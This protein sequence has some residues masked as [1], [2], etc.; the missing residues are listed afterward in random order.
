MNLRLERV[1]SGGVS[2]GGLSVK[3]FASRRGSGREGNIDTDAEMHAL[4][5]ITK[6]V[7][8]GS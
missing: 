5:V 4:L 6:E 3:L 1:R 7:I 2:E 8:I